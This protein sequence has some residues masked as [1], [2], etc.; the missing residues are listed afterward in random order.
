ML[1]GVVTV[2]VAL[3][4]WIILQFSGPVFWVMQGLW[5]IGVGVAIST[6]AALVRA[7]QQAQNANTKVDPNILQN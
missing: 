3:E 1:V 2:T 4:Y 5:A 7:G 6:I